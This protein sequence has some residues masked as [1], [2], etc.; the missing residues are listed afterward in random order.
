MDANFEEKT[1]EGYLNSEL[2]RSSRFFFPFGQVQEGSIGLD[3]AF[4]VRNPF[5]WPRLG[6]PLWRA[7]GPDGVDLLDV[8]K[9]ME[10]HLSSIAKN[11]PNLRVNLLLQYK[12]PEYIS[13]KSGKEW[14]H[15]RRPYFRYGLDDEQHS[16]L[17]HIANTF[18]ASALV[19]YAAPA[20]R[21]VDELVRN[22]N[23]R[24]TVKNTNFTRVERLY[25]HKVNTFIKSGTHSIACSEP[26][27]IESTDIFT[28]IDAIQ[29]PETEGNSSFLISFSRGLSSALR[30]SQAAPYRQAFKE[31]L[32]QLESERLEDYPLF[33]AHVEAGVFSEIMGTRWISAF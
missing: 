32:A 16:L 1:F 15:W 19:L 22:H 10:R 12:R 5:F 14:H 4:F 6:L 28:A 18:K 29:A 9:E 33:K 25:G 31:R 26:E 3:A 24:A 20:V 17:S 2:D 13:I 8:A 11:I 27:R 7:F 30:D 21:K 23:N